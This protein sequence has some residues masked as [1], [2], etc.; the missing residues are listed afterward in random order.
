LWD[1]VKDGIEARKQANAAKAAA[2]AEMQ[3]A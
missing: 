2:Q 1:H 3:A